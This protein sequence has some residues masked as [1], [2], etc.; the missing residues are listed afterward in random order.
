MATSATRK[1]TI[2]NTVTMDDERVVEFP[3]KRRMLKE[4]LFQEDG[5]IQVRLDFVNGETRLFTIPEAL[6]AKF[7]AHG[8][9][10]KLGDEVAGL[11]DV[12]DAVLAID[13]LMER[14]NNGDWSIRREASGLAGTSVLARAL[15]E[16]TGKPASVIKDF[17]STK[18]QAEKV[19]LR[20]N[21]KIAPIVARLE[22][23]KA[24][25]GPAIDTDAMLETL[26]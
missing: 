12:E 20:R 10:Q 19:E 11:E 24:K 25:K 4:S 5:S 7:A 14:L 18:S 21:A 17:L 3:G 2:Y 6:A 26:A 8:A 13:D 9:E 23:E 16:A 1:E 22:A 15:V